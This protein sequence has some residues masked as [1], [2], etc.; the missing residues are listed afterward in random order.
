MPATTPRQPERST[1]RAAVTRKARAPY[2]VSARHVGR[3]YALVASVAVVLFVAGVGLVLLTRS[4]TGSFA[5]G[6]EHSLGSATAP[7][8]VEEWSDFE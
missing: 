2:V 3:M 1:P 8:V 7:V 6:S 4:G 5:A